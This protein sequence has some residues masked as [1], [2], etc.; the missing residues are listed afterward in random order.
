MLMFANG[1][2]GGVT[3]DDLGSLGHWTLG[4]CLSDPLPT[5]QT[6]HPLKVSLVEPAAILSLVGEVGC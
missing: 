5:P 4:R 3:D 6:L 2:E 1:W